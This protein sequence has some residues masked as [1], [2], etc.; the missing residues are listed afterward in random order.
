MPM[1]DNYAT[2]C[3]EWAHSDDELPVWRGLGDILGDR[4]GWHFVPPNG[5]LQEMT[6]CFGLAGDVAS[7]LV[8]SE[9]DAASMC[10]LRTVKYSST[11]RRS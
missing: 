11:A 5:H 2:I 8:P 6:W 10:M 9:A 3:S 4:V 1:P 7:P